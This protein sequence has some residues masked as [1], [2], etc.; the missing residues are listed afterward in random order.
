MDAIALGAPIELL[1]ALESTA[2]ATRYTEAL[3]ARGLFRAAL[4]GGAYGTACSL[5]AAV[6]PWSLDPTGVAFLVRECGRL[7]PGSPIAALPLRLPAVW[8]QGRPTAA[9][10]PE[11]QAAL[12]LPALCALARTPVAAL[13][14]AFLRA[15]PWLLFTGWPPAGDPPLDRFLRKAGAL[16]TGSRKGLIRDRDWSL[17]M[18]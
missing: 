13:M 7:P 8:A 11:T 3:E 2:G 6:H 5:L 9:A 1:R 4:A 12:A 17:G 15:R 16:L 18:Q 10:A 14:T